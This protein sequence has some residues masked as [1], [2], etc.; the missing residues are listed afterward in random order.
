MKLKYNIYTQIV[1]KLLLCTLLLESCTG[2]VFKQ[3]IAPSKL[4]AAEHN[5]LIEE[6]KVHSNAIEV[7]NQYDSDGMAKA[8]DN[9]KNAFEDKG[10]RK[11]VV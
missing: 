7:D 9:K 5:R 11:S 1:A 6:K 2:G 8:M 4:T 10:D 3:S